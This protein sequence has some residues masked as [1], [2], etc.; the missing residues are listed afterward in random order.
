MPGIRRRF[1]RSVAM[2]CG[3]GTDATTRSSPGVGTGGA[4]SAHETMIRSV[5]SP[6]LTPSSIGP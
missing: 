5:S 1:P 4:A 2:S 3:T 6:R